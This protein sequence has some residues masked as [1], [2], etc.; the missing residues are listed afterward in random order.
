[1]G[2]CLNCLIS[3]CAPDQTTNVTYEKDVLRYRLNLTGAKAVG[4]EALIKVCI[5]LV[6][7]SFVLTNEQ[8]RRERNVHE[9]IIIYPFY[10]T[11]G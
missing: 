3:V 7:L 9:C 1:M 2:V 5:F 8:G 6:N 11:T 10:C 4:K